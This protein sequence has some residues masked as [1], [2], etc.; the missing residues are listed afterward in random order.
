MVA[1]AENVVQFIFSLKRKQPIRLI[2]KH[3]STNQFNSQTGINQL[4]LKQESVPVRN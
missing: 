3:E 4:I 2:L 1:N